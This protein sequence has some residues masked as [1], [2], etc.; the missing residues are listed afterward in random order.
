MVGRIQDI[1]VEIG[2]DTA[3]LQTVLKGVNTELRNIQS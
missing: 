1:T 3:K 2:G